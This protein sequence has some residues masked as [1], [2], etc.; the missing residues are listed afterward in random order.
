MLLLATMLTFTACSGDKD[1]NEPDET[2]SNEPAANNITIDSLAIALNRLD[3]IQDSGQL[4]HFDTWSVGSLKGVQVQAQ[5]LTS[6][7]ESI[8][9]INLRKDCGGEYYYLWEDAHI[10]QKELPSLYEA[11]KTI[12][13]EISRETDHNEK[14]IY[15]TK[16][17][18]MVFAEN[19]GKGWSLKFSVDSHKS[20]SFIN[21]TPTELDALI[22]LLEKAN[23][24]LNQAKSLSLI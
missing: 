17:N 11:I 18:V 12:K 9:Y 4:V 24:K 7:D 21:L 20:N 10:F 3:S 5:K 1:K 8:L 6:G 2:P 15:I 22:E 19:D 16:D 14:Y 13:K 23:D